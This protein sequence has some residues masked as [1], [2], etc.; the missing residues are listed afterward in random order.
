MK[1][2]KTKCWTYQQW[3]TKIISSWNDFLVKK[4]RNLFINTSIRFEIQN[5]TTQS[6]LMRSSSERLVLYR[7][8]STTITLSPDWM[9]TI[10]SA[11]LN[12]QGVNTNYVNWYQILLIFQSCL[13]FRTPNRHTPWAQYII[14]NTNYYR[15]RPTA[16]IP[17]EFQIERDIV[18]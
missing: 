4:Q 18:K 14:I 11:K 12:G 2:K 3:W 13:S 17:T 15:K 9:I 1:S 8:Q 5:L 10:Q 6:Q 16:W 7:N